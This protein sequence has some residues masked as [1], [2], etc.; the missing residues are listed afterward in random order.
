MILRSSGLRSQ[1]GW[2]RGFPG[3]SSV[4]DSRSPA[5]DAHNEMAINSNDKI[6]PWLN[7]QVFVRVAEDL[8]TIRTIAGRLS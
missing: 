2:D 1:R 3:G 8:E 5:T 6:E 4:F 7:R